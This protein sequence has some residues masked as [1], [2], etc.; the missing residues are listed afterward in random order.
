MAENI[1]A[2]SWSPKSRANCDGSKTRGRWLA[3]QSISASDTKPSPLLLLF[4]RTRTALG[5]ARR[6]LLGSSSPPGSFLGSVCCCSLLRS[7]SYFRCCFVACY[8]ACILRLVNAACS[9]CMMVAVVSVLSFCCVC[10]AS[11]H[12]CTL[13]EGAESNG[14][15]QGVRKRGREI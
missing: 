11:S 5:T 2:A 15:K 14:S 3:I 10:V 8:F 1:N 12:A 6:G 7:C 9:L 4:A 13:L